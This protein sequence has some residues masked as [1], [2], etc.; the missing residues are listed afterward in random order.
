MWDSTIHV[1]FAFWNDSLL[2][3]FRAVLFDATEQF[4]DG[5][6]QLSNNIFW[7]Y[8]VLLMSNKT[9]I[10]KLNNSKFADEEKGKKLLY[11]FVGE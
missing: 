2:L 11:L 8:I 4:L 6:G 5:K 10:C 9:F 7:L 1:F 3:D